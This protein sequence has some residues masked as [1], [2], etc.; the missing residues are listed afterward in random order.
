MI[1]VAGV[2]LA[3][4]DGC[5]RGFLLGEILWLGEPVEQRNGAVFDLDEVAGV[6]GEKAGGDLDLANV[7]RL[8]GAAAATG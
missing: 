8:E 3:G 1:V 6:A 4:G 5:G 2:L 7:A